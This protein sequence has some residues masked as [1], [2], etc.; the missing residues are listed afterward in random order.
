M[1]TLKYKDSQVVILLT[2]SDAMCAAHALRNMLEP[3]AYVP[4]PLTKLS[5]ELDW[6]L[7]IGIYEQNHKRPDVVSTITS[8]I[9]IGMVMGAVVLSF[10]VPSVW[11]CALAFAGF[12]VGAIGLTRA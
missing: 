5:D 8:R 11:T 9:G 10:F 1:P 7:G 4:K 3:L 6:S 12:I 2:R